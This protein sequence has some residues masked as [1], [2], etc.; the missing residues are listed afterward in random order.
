MGA[1]VVGFDGLH[2]HRGWRVSRSAVIGV[3][4]AGESIALRLSNDA[5]AP[6]SRSYAMSV[7]RRDRS[8]LSASAAGPAPR[9][10]ELDLVQLGESEVDV[11]QPLL[12]S[13]DHRLSPQAEV[14]LKVRAVTAKA[15]TSAMS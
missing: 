14:V 6:V 15:A 8:R 5:L 10:R 9:R 2:D 12:Q 13:L 11:L 1:G 7:R 3:E 4:A